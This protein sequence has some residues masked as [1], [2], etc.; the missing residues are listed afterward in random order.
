[1]EKNPEAGFDINFKN[2]LL[3]FSD[4]NNIF[5]SPYYNFQDPTLYE[6]MIF[7]ADPAFLDPSTNKMEIPLDSPAA[8]AGS[9]AGSLI[10]DLKGSPRPSPADLGA[11]NAIEFEN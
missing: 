9:N 6:N 3:R 1:M 11:L 4:P 7:N 5:T 2:C 8:G 10:T